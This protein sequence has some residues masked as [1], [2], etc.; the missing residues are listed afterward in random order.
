MG[1]L[2]K[3]QGHGDGGASSRESAQGNK[4]K[5]RE[6]GKEREMRGAL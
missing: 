3:R 4:D 5:S 6:K 1:A 2:R